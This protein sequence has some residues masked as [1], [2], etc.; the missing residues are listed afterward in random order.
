MLYVPQLYLTL[1]DP[2]DKAHQAPLFMEFSRQEY[3]SELLF[4]TPENLPDPGIK[5]LSLALQE[6][7]LLAGP[8][9]KPKGLKKKIVLSND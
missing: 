5:L 2:M 9:G 8:Q 4:P 6:N 1:C 7:S 3:W